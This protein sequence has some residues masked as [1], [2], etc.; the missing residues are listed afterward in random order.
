MNQVKSNF[1]I[2][3]A[4]ISTL[5]FSL[6][7]YGAFIII[8]EFEKIFK[9]FEADLPLQTSLLIG[10][11]RYWGI[12]ALISTF[13]LLNVSKCKSNKAMTLLTLLIVLSVLLVPLT[14]WGLYSPVLAGSGQT[15]T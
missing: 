4:S 12:F 6:F 1:Q 15:T 7:S 14:I 13:I 8:N 11:Y 10:T 3:A 5:Y 9:S 2:I